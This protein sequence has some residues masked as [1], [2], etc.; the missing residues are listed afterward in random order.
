MSDLLLEPWRHNIPTA[1]VPKP[2]PS[3]PPPL[4]IEKAVTSAPDIARATDKIVAARVLQTMANNIR[5]GKLATTPKLN[6]LQDAF[7]A[8]TARVEAAAESLTNRMDTAAGTTETAITKF[9][10]AVEQVEATAKSID[11]AANQLTNG[12]PPLGN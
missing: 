10:H 8:F 2:E 12:G 3:Q 11:D 6:G 4:T 9:G 1:T 7:K 5:E